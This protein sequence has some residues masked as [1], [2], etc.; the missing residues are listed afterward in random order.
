ACLR[1]DNWDLLITDIIMPGLDGLG[2]VRTL[3]SLGMGVPIIA[4]TAN[5]TSELYSALAE[6]DCYAFVNK[7]F[8]WVYMLSLVER[9]VGPPGPLP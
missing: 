3:R 6:L 8:D 7:P 9:I 2:L 4:V 5:A 1:S